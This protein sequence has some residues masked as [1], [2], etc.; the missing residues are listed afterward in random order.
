MP[1]GQT[2]AGFSLEGACARQEG[3]EQQEQPHRTLLVMRAAGGGKQQQGEMGQDQL[4]LASRWGWTREQPS[5]PYLTLS[6]HAG[7]GQGKTQS[8]GWGK[9]TSTSCRRTLT[10]KSNRPEVHRRVRPSE[11]QGWAQPLR[12]PAKPLCQQAKP[13]HGSQAAEATAVFAPIGTRILPLQGHHS[14]TNSECWHSALRSANQQAAVPV[15]GGSHWPLPLQGWK[16]H[17]LHSLPSSHSNSPGEPRDHRQHSGG[18]R[19]Q[20]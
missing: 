7:H 20:H 19:S 14:L 5:S 16:H 2:G 3:E 10:E 13:S 15:E 1:Q 18:W 6:N 12:H 17:A 4:L 11:A 9:S 8:R